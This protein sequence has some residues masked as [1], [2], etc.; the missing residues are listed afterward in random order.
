MY[1]YIYTYVC[2]CKRT[3]VCLCLC[4]YL[5]LCRV[6]VCACIHIHTRTYVYMHIVEYIST[7]LL[8]LCTCAYLK[9]ERAGLLSQLQA[10]QSFSVKKSAPLQLSKVR[11]IGTTHRCCNHEDSSWES[12]RAS[13]LVEL[14]VFACGVPLI[15]SAGLRKHHATYVAGLNAAMGES[16]KDGMPAAL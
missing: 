1:V 11:C 14:L 16:A 8:Y 7:P 2:R 4:L 10:V 15:D 13:S 3:C 5:C 6:C 9:K 12:W